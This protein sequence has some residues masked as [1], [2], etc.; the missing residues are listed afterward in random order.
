MARDRGIALAVSVRVLIT[1][2]LLVVYPRV[3]AWM[4]RD[5]LG[6]KVAT[7]LG[8]EVAVGSIEVSLGH[9]VLRDIEVRG[10]A[11]RSAPL[12]HVDRV[13]IDFDPWRS[14][15]GSVRARRGAAS[16]A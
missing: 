13:D 11:R 1:V 5:K 14:L 16:T 8:R 10:T 2:G 3:G 4:I 12:V 7:R 6:S 9:A 15:V